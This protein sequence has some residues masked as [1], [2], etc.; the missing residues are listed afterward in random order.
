VWKFWIDV[1][2]TF[3]D[4]I[5]ENPA[6]HELT[7]KV[8]SSAITK[9]RWPGLSDKLA[10]MDE[11]LSTEI[12]D[13]W[14]GYRLIWQD[15]RG[16]QVG[17]SRVN[18]TTAEGKIAFE[19]CDIAARDNVAYYELHSPEPSPIFAV[20]RLAQVRLD[21]PLPD[22]EMFLG[23]TR[24]T[25]ALLTRRGAKTVFAVTAG[26]QDLLEIGEQD[27][28]NLFELTIRKTRPLYQSVIEIPERVAA[29]GVVLRPIDIA[30]TTEALQLAKSSGAESIAICLLHSFRNDIHERAVA[31]IAHDVGFTEVSLSSVVSPLIKIVPRAETTVLDAYLNPVIR[32]YADEIL[33]RLSTGSR[34][35]LMT[36]H[37]GLVSRDRFTGKDSVLSGPAGGVVGFA[38]AAEQAGFRKAIG[39]DMGGT[40]TDVARFEGIFEK[41]FETRKAGVR[42]VAPI[43]AIETVAAG[44]G[45]ICNFNGTRLTVGPE[46]A[47]SVPGP[48]CYGRGGPLAI[49]DINVHLG[50]ICES[51]FPFSLDRAAV[52]RRLDE[53]A[54][55]IQAATGQE[56]S[57]DELANGFW[58]IANHNMASAIRT[59]SV[60][61]GY[62]PRDYVLVAFGGAGP[63]HA[64]GVADQLGI[65]QVL[66]HPH[67]SVLSAAGI[68]MAPRSASGAKSVLREFSAQLLAELEHNFSDLT[69]AAANELV[70]E[71]V[72]PQQIQFRRSLDMRFVGT[73]PFLNI[74]LQ[75]NAD[76]RAEFL[77]QHQQLF[78]Y[79]QQRSIEVVAIRVEATLPGQ[80]Y[81]P[82]GRLPY[83]QAV[84]AQEFQDC[85]VGETPRQVPLFD[86]RNLNCG[87]SIRGP[88][89]IADSMTTIWVD[90]TWDAVVL[91]A[92]QLV[93]TK[94]ASLVDRIRERISTEKVDPVRLEIFSNSFRSLARQMGITLQRTSVSVNVKDRLDF[95]CAIFNAQGD[96]VVNAPHI[97]VHLGAMSE[98]VREVIRQNPLV[99]EGDVYVTNDPYA[100]GSHLPDV[101]VVTPV[102]V[103]G[104]LAFWVASRGHHAEIGGKT[105]GSMPPDATCLADEGVLIQNLKLIDAGQEHF[106]RLE[107]LL[108]SG[109]YPSRNASDNVADIRAEV[110]ANQ[111]GANGLR[112]LA[113]TYSLAV[114]SAYMDFLLDAAEI[115]VRAALR[116]IPDG[117][118][119]SA[120]QMDNGRRIAVT[121]NKRAE[122]IR[123]DFSGTDAVSPD[124]LNANRAICMAAI[125]YVMRCLLESDI[126]LNE[127]VVRPVT[128][129][130]PECFLN[131]RPGIDAAHTPA[132]VGGNVET[133]QR[134]VDV[135]LGAL[136][137]AA[138]SQGTMNNWLMGDSTFGY[139]ETLGG[140]SG[141]TSVGPGADAVHTHM[142]NTRLT[143]PEVLETRFPVRLVAFGVAR[144]TGGKGRHNGG[145][146]MIRSV[147]FLRALTVS[148]LT[149]R[150]NSQ[151]Y[152]MA[153][154]GPGASGQNL[155]R[156][157]G[158]L[159]DEPLPSRTQ[160]QVFPGDRLTLITPGGG[161]WGT[162][163]T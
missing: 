4:C 141:A 70:A 40:S 107:A 124:N 60:A 13:F 126:P 128:L 50:R 86:W 137:L 109:P 68:R 55:K 49:T 145:C 8:L 39:F 54:E 14:R 7:I 140:G 151:P 139:Y 76:C 65:S 132:I 17:E 58:E 125:M 82:A 91:A 85:V 63:Q 20:R 42:I 21:E 34:L 101:S 150:R 108:R 44:G 28:P 22:L 5:A 120:D 105:P 156:R 10:F 47:G 116:K 157:A 66:V 16:E 69:K 67:A 89:L 154:G 144:G 153:G 3:T 147:E 48:A 88:A 90:D 84:V 87:D 6:G 52:D 29:D 71:G 117:Q 15:D 23:T 130:L 38:R 31:A 64:T 97:P 92:R 152:G 95:S 129:E 111:V 32:S 53:L 75:P 158:A 134:I 37:G 73:E 51:H 163:E 149:S 135:L 160:I 36:S 93:L 2:G 113:K 72:E 131:P 12:V 127:G 161:G 96:L 114:V 81:E 106:E 102:F 112:E 26:F 27:R 159:V 122:Q 46:S 133:S 57:R 41:E 43:L 1:G 35:Q 78:G 142:S 115:Q 24:G 146:G 33:R 61:K 99:R 11:S 59:V 18:G 83:S 100:G 103:Q 162:S 80:Q 143:D 119:H 30:A 19:E 9:N 62:D 155:L 74:P 45:S 121:I 110:A 56:L 138:A 98:T 25:N 104:R 79:V 148:L 77:R 118:Y 136:G 94:Q 123:I